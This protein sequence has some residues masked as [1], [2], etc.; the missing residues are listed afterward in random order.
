M[1]IPAQDDQVLWMRGIECHQRGNLDEAERCYRRIDPHHPGYPYVLANLG[2][3]LDARGEY[4]AAESSFLRALALDPTHYSTLVNYSNTLLAIGR[5]NEA[6][7]LCRRGIAAKPDGMEAHCLLGNVLSAVGRLAEAEIAYGR[8]LAIRQDA[9][10]ALLGLGNV[11]TR[12][13]RHDE[14]VLYYR[15]ALAIRPGM[16][17]A[18]GNLGLVLTTLGKLEE[19]QAT[20][21]AAIALDPENPCH[22]L[23]LGLCLGALNRLDQAQ[24]VYRQALAIRPDN[25][26]ILS[27]LLF[28]HNYREDG[29]LTVSLAD[30]R[31]YGELVAAKATPFV[32]H[33]DHHAPHRRLRIG[34]VSGD[35]L[36]HPVGFFLDGV[37]PWVVQEALDLY[38]YSNC[39]RED[40]LT[41]RLRDSIP[42]WRNVMGMTDETLARRI[43]A[44]EIDI[45]MDLSGHTG[46]NRLPVFAWKPAPIQ[47]TWLGFFATTGLASMDYILGDPYNLPEE[48]AGHFVETPW[49]LPQCYLAFT[50]PDLAIGVN[51]LPA[52]RDGF[53]T[54]GSCNKINKLNDGVIACWAR[55]LDA[56]PESRLLIKNQS[57]ADP[58][59]RQEMLRR[60]LLHGIPSERIL[61]EGPSSRELYFEVYHRI[62]IALDPF[63][64][65]GVT[66]SVEGLWMG[67]PFITRKGKRYLSH[68][69]ESILANAGLA[70]WIAGDIEEYVAKAVHFSARREELAALRLDLRPR[71]L[72]SPLFDTRGFAG[73]LAQAWSGMWH[74][75]CAQGRR[76]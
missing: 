66:T 6:E 72:R 55:L 29:D 75:W 60:F 47:V 59:V 45:L 32:H 53:I 52:A 2:L 18:M 69:G 71:V 43:H 27:N 51:D 36:N 20:L 41:Q 16:A 62:D 44:D 67:V 40:D 65:P 10:E 54:F 50:P 28:L 35:L 21:Q 46:R 57:L 30:A 33:P 70:D 42:M 58:M 31:H 49:R 14:A 12:L 19:A 1:L 8:A 5:M 11:M 68:Q 56:V 7:S 3:L 76:G 24:A 23:N 73:H 17:G 64:Y 63:P 39:D 48:E 38:V 9:V 61:L 37:I 13:G 22:R 26:E 74:A 25:L 4:A 15:R 34:L